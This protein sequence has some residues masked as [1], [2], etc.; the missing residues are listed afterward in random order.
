M[1][2]SI[3]FHSFYL[4]I[5]LDCIPLV[6]VEIPIFELP[7]EL[8]HSKLLFT[9]RFFRFANTPPCSTMLYLVE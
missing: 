1:P 4:Y 9:R 7:L 6:I 3:L 5:S 2:F 8:P